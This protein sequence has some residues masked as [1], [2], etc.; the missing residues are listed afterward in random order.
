[1]AS[2]RSTSKYMRKKFRSAKT[3]KASEKKSPSPA[4]RP[5]PK[6]ITNA[7]PNQLALDNENAIQLA[8]VN[9]AN[10]PSD[11]DYAGVT[12]HSKAHDIFRK[13]IE[14]EFITSII[15]D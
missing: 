4:S 9:F 14:V 6:P 1:M 12:K 5:N 13:K 7:D 15:K 3:R 2:T 10:D 8:L 11:R